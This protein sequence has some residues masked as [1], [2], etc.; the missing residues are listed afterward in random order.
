MTDPGL[1]AASDSDERPGPTAGWDAWAWR[2]VRLVLTRVNVARQP[3]R[4]D[5]DHGQTD[6]Q[7]RARSHHRG[8]ST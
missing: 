2:I 8:P 3:W 5:A 1:G 4:H 7:L 6:D